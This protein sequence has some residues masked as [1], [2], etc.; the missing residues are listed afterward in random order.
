MV[1]FN[2]IQY[3]RDARKSIKD[4][5]EVA[6]LSYFQSYGIPFPVYALPGLK[7]NAKRYLFNL[8]ICLALIGRLA[9]RE[10]F[11]KTYGLTE[12]HFKGG[13]KPVVLIPSS[14]IQDYWIK[15]FKAGNKYAKAAIY[16]V[17]HQNITNKTAIALRE[18]IAAI[19]N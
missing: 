5:L 17:A 14:L 10:V 6:I 2:Q 8:D 1:P 13:A 18:N 4:P 3:L 15:E 11:I 19:L 16:V 9:A 12:F 7:E